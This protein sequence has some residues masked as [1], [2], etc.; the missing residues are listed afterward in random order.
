MRFFYIRVMGKDATYFGVTSIQYNSDYGAQ[1]TC[2]A[3][4]IQE[5]I[6]IRDIAMLCP[7]LQQLRCGVFASLFFGF[8]LVALPL[9]EGDDF[10][11]P[12]QL[13]LQHRVEYC[14]L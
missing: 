2:I 13:M 11:G 9:A 3:T 8:F 1:G 4:V 5:T 12:P 6:R 7:D 14:Y 10:R